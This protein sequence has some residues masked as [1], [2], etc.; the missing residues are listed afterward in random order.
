M[1]EEDP[2]DIIVFIWIALILVLVAWHFMTKA[3][4][5]FIFN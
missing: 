1:Y 4:F 2:I 3:L 5:Y